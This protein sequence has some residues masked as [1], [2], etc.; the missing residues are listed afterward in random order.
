[1]E[2]GVDPR[3]VVCQPLEKERLKDRDG[4]GDEIEI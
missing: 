4:D 3:M 1:V 2:D